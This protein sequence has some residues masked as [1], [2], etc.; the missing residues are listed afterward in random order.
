M[1][2]C[3]RKRVLEVDA[4]TRG[5][6]ALERAVEEQLKHVPEHQ[7]Q[8]I[9]VRFWMLQSRG[10]DNSPIFLCRVY[11]CL[12]LALLRTSRY[13]FGNKEVAQE[14]FGEIL[15]VFPMPAPNATSSCR[16]GVFN[17]SCSY[18]ASNCD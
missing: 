8:L 14:R 17:A 7:Q 11:S 12:M 6:Q 15:E 16:N 18:S 4:A 5:A 2:L 1:K 9:Q 10:R 3:E 13:L